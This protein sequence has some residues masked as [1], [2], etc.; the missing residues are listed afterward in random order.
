MVGR[1]RCPA[2]GLRL[3]GLPLL[4][5]LLLCGLAR[6]A[7]QPAVYLSNI[8]NTPSAFEEFLYPED[9]LSAVFNGTAGTPVNTFSAYFSCKA[10]PC[11]VLLNVRDT[12]AVEETGSP[13]PFTGTYLR[14]NMS[15]SLMPEQ[16]VTVA[17]ARQRVDF[18]IQDANGG[19]WVLPS[20]GPFAFVLT[21][22]QGPP[23]QMGALAGFTTDPNVS[24]SGGFAVVYQSYFTN[25]MWFYNPSSPLL[26]SIGYMPR[27]SPPPAVKEGGGFTDGAYALHFVGFSSEP[28]SVSPTSGAWLEVIGSAA[29]N[30]SLQ[31]QFGRS[32]NDNQQLVT[33]ATSLRVGAN[34][35]VVRV[36]LAPISK[37]WE[38]T[39]A[40]N[41]KVVTSSA[42]L[43]GGVK[44]AVASFNPPSNLVASR[45]T[46]DAGYVQLVVTQRWDPKTSQPTDSVNFGVTLVGPLKLPVSGALSASYTAAFRR[47]RAATAAMRTAQLALTAS[48]GAGHEP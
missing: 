31:A 18:S 9:T 19:P 37:G 1:R 36:A 10:Y 44:V 3:A 29:Q 42:T 21:V 7:S 6:A 46:I 41:G 8:D 45:V 47:A 2:S 35:V 27:P 32:I 25:Y 48:G 14:P 40:A 13:N 22:P 33:R 11:T 16:N 24:S 39:A 5:S 26:F 15:S 34:T 30:F 43:A 17:S 28:V 38:V 4:L 20:S 23:L 12:L